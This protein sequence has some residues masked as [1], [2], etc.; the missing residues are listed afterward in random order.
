MRLVYK[1][2]LGPSRSRIPPSERMGL[3]GEAVPR[4][5]AST[6]GHVAS[7]IQESSVCC[8]TQQ[9]YVPPSYREATQVPSL[10]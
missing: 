3:D 1:H 8:R 2:G 7:R 4:V 9:R 5:L 10:A 6:I